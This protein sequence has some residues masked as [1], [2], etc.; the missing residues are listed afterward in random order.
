[1]RIHD[2]SIDNRPRERLLRQGVSVL[3]DAE[4][5]AI[6]LQN[7]CYGENAIDRTERENYGR[8]LKKNLKNRCGSGLFCLY[9]NLWF[10]FFVEN[11]HSLL[12]ILYLSAMLDMIINS[13][14]FAEVNNCLGAF[15]VELNV[16][17]R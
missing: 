10:K 2:I 11:T 13:S 16:L 15:F 9:S 5:L 17:L 1:M 8:F 6:I 7:G 12:I 3:S 14:F 4:L